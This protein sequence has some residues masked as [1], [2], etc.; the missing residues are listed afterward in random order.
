MIEDDTKLTSCTR[1]VR[2]SVTL[3]ETPI[4]RFFR[5]VGE[6][7]QRSRPPAVDADMVARCDRGEV[8]L[9]EWKRVNRQ[10]G[11]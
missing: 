9:D 11:R 2:P 8:T 5:R 3:M 10:R 1:T 6:F 7:W 4:Q